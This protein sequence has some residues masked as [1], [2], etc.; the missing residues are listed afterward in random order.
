MEI[1]QKSFFSKDLSTN[2]AVLHCEKRTVYPEIVI[3]NS[4]GMLIPICGKTK[5]LG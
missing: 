2:K 1:C 3:H 4:L 5:G